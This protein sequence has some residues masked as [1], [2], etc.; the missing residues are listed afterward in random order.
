MSTPLDGV[1]FSFK[2]VASGLY[3]GIKDNAD[4]AG[5]EVVLVSAVHKPRP[6]WFLQAEQDAKYLVN[7]SAPDMCLN[8]AYESTRH[9]DT[10]Q[11]WNRNSGPSELW[12]LIPVSSGNFCLKNKKSG[13]VAGSNF[14]GVGTTVAQLHAVSSPWHF[15]RVVELEYNLTPQPALVSESD[16]TLSRGCTTY[17]DQSA[18]SGEMIYNIYVPIYAFSGHLGSVIQD[19]PR[20]VELG[21]STIL[22]MPIHPLGVPVGRHPAIG[23]PYAVADHYSIEP[24]LG[25]SSD[26]ADLVNQTHSWGLKIILDVVLNHTAW[27]HP[28]VTQRPELFVHTGGRKNSSDT[29]SQA[30]WFKDVAQLDYKSNHDVREYMSAMLVW[31]MKSFKVDGFRFDTVDNPYGDNRMIPAPAWLFIG[32][33]LKALNPNVILLG[34][35]TNPE[36]SLK[37][38]NMDYNNYSLQPALVSA[39]RSEDASDLGRAFIE[40]KLQHPAGMLHTSI[41][42]TW[43]MDLDLNMYGGPDETLVA[44][45][46]NFCI[47]GVPMLFAGEEAGNDRGGVNTH[48]TI[49]WCGLHSHRFSAF[50]KGLGLL[51]RGSTALREGATVWW[52]PGRAS[53]GLIVFVRKSNIQECLVAINFSSSAS[54]GHIGS[55]PNHGW[56]EVTPP[57]AGYPMGH[58]VPPS[59]SLGPWDFAIFTQTVYEDLSD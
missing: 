3:L 36:L 23:S 20:I 39:T 52:T 44:A 54:Q 47:D 9:G 35:C 24:G 11:Q 58:P 40:L 12:N 17:H 41:M 56:T 37:P 29:I 34:E 26:F 27:N 48:D 5:G 14:H 7:A 33:N 59:V 46:F 55:W 21:F 51:R 6:R 57:G 2:H 38:F 13:L 4:Y 49:N 16:S 8:V 18:L 30:F 50:Y 25:T 15:W 53:P 19:L 45:V 43:D 31:W 28:F 22:L 42:Q 32:Q 10:L 1:A